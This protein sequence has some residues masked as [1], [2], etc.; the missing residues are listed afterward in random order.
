MPQVRPRT[1]QFLRSGAVSKT[2]SASAVRPAMSVVS[3]IGC[4]KLQRSA[5]ATLRKS[6]ERKLLRFTFPIM[7]VFISRK[8][9]PSRARIL[10]LAILTCAFAGAIRADL[11]ETTVLPT[12]STLNLD[13]GAIG[14][15][16]GDLLWNGSTIAPQGSAT[17]YNV[18]NSGSTNFNGLP[19]SYWVNLAGAGRST[20]LAANVL[21]AGDAFVANTG[22]G[23]IA[24]VLVVSNSS[25]A[26]TL[27]FTTFGAAASTAPAVSQILN[28][29]SAIP[30]GY[31]NYGIAPSS[32]FVVKGSNLSDPG[33]PVLQD[34]QA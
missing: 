9:E 1:R 32:I 8:S 28:N 13:T 24:K 19:Q 31:P 22:S 16:G 18:G 30:P 12:N 15:S 5:I 7:D 25:G 21:V 26:I 14:A 6:P 17:V 29:S 20:P 3:P 33:T 34:T 23:K 4:R 11:S 2:Q 10:A 27:Q